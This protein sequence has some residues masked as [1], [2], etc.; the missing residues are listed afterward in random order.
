MRKLPMRKVFLLIAFVVCLILATAPAFGQS[1]KISKGQ[2]IYVP[3]NHNY[4]IDGTNWI[5]M[6]QLIIRN[7][8]LNRQ[9]TVNSIELYGPDGETLLW[10]YL[11]EVELGPLNSMT[12]RPS[13][14]APLSAEVGRPGWIVRWTASKAVNAPIIESTTA[15]V[16]S[17]C[18]SMTSPPCFRGVSFSPARVIKEVWHKWD[19]D[20]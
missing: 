17:S 1:F 4:I 13:L 7:I 14:A 3:A 10:E 8:D 12:F 19:Q 20:D 2:I 15:I 6:T 11:D 18:A 9:I 5:V 16:D